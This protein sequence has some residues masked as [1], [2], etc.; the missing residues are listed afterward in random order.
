MEHSTVTNAIELSNVNDISNAR[1]RHLTPA[2]ASLVLADDRVR[3]LIK[4][5]LRIR[6]RILV[7][8]SGADYELFYLQAQLKLCI[9]KL[10]FWRRKA[11]AANMI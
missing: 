9:R 2:K 7:L 10:R 1:Y 5:E 6:R 8:Q 4:E 11:R 3:F